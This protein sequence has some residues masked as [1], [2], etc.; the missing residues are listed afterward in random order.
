MNCITGAA[1]CMFCV[2]ASFKSQGL[3]FVEFVEEFGAS[4][5][6]TA[7]MMGIT[8]CGMSLFCR[9]TNIIVTY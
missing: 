2:I 7:W 3:L 5:A 4:N 1:W 6:L 8:A 9:F